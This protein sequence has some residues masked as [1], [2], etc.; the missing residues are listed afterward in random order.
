MHLN[1]KI[2]RIR[3]IQN[4]KKHL[5]DKKYM[6]LDNTRSIFH[7]NGTKI[8]LHITYTEINTVEIVF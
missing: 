2:Y 8:Q 4:I 3:R 1:I 7:F 5:F 6:R